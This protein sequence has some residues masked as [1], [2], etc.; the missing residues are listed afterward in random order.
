MVGSLLFGLG[1]G[2]AGCVHPASFNTAID[3]QRLRASK[4]GTARSVKGIR[5]IEGSGFSALECPKR[6]YVLADLNRIAEAG[7]AE[8]T[9]AIPDQAEPLRAFV[10]SSYPRPAAVVVPYECFSRNGL[11]P[12]P[13]VDEFLSDVT[14]LYNQLS[15]EP[16]II[17]E[18][19][20]KSN[21]SDGSYVLRSIHTDVGKVENTTNSTAK[22]YRGIYNFSMTRS[23]FKPGRLEGVNFVNSTPRLIECQLKSIE[24]SDD[25]TCQYR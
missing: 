12:S 19:N 5:A 11:V 22:I 16:T 17:I 10:R 2:L 18:L 8:L 3:M 14:S 15:R 21:P 20:V 13:V 7:S 23:G 6:A 24:D 1:L 25:S 4:E 9:S